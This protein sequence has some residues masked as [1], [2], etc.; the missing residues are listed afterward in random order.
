M[1]KELVEHIKEKNPKRILLQLPEGLK[2]RAL[3]IAKGIEEEGIEVILSADP[4]YGA[5]DLRDDEAMQLKCDLLVHVGHESFYKNFET[6]V[7]VLYYPWKMDLN[8]DNIDFSVIGEERIGLLTSLQYE[9]LLD[10]ASS[11]LKE[12]GK[13]PVIGGKILGCFTGSAEKIKDKV[14][15]FLFIGSGTFHSTAV[16]GKKTY[17]LDLEKRRIEVS[18]DLPEK[19]RYARIAKAKE[20]ETFGILVSSKKG[21]FNLEKAE[22]ARKYLKNKDKKAFI[23]IMDEISNEKLEGIKADSF[24]N[25]ACPRI[26]LRKTINIDDL[27]EVFG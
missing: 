6:S 5:C 3:E 16:K 19:K 10:V 4:C 26:E 15:A 24:V 2:T 8:I 21:Q 23:L 14:D 18:S 25:T 13:K 7:S 11:K 27:E 1:I 20:A 17:V 12:A 22:E 9:D